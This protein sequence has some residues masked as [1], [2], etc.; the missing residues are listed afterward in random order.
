MSVPIAFLGGLA[1][2]ARQGIVIKG[3]N[4]LEDLAQADTFVFDKT[5]TCLLYTSRLQQKE[6]YRQHLQ[7][8]ECGSEHI[9]CCF[10][11]FSS[12]CQW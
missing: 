5:G 1:S 12:Y 7:I 8:Y 11:Q 4:Y 3:A 10:L 6:I 9:P 2:A